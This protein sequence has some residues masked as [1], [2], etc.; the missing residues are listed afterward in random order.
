MPR[1]DSPYAPIRLR[2]EVWWTFA[3]KCSREGWIHADGKIAGNLPDAIWEDL[4]L[5]MIRVAHE[6]GL[7][8]SDVFGQFVANVMSLRQWVPL[9]GQYE[10]CGRQIF[11]LSD[12]LVDMLAHTDV[13]DCTL[14]NWKAPFDAFFVRFGKQDG[15]VLPFDETSG[16][17]L[18]GVFVAITPWDEEKV[19]DRR[20]LK[21]GFTTVKEDGSGVM[22]P[23]HFLDLIPSEH[24]LPV[25][26]AIESALARKFEALD[27]ED[28]SP[29]RLRTVV[30]SMTC[31]GEKPKSLRS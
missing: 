2:D 26:D 25:H 11:D 19:S 7:S 9:I 17:Y 20:R 21:L 4:C 29:S 22:M 10:L 18:D 12:D 5:P 15:V 24:D 14:K 3:R 28:R 16:E 13:S 31:V 1:E 6:E 23:G 30:G 27:E 8:E